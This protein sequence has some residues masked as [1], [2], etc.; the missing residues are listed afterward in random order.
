M[1]TAARGRG[2]AEG[3]AIASGGAI[4]DRPGRWA[5]MEAEFCRSIRELADLLI[6]HDGPNVA[7]TNRG[8]VLGCA[9]A[10][11]RTRDTGSSRF[12]SVTSATGAP[13]AFEGGGSGLGEKRDRVVLRYSEVSPVGC[14]KNGGYFGALRN[15]VA[16]C[17]AFFLPER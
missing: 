16:P 12:A 6:L 8:G 4:T 14:A 5:R 17:G 3:G 15:L 2:H 13:D 7:G 11:I 9:S 10:G 1:V